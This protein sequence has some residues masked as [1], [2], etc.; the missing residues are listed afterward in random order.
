MAEA[1]AELA[2]AAEDLVECQP[3]GDVET[4]TRD[5]RTGFERPPLRPLRPA[6]RQLLACNTKIARSSLDQVAIRHGRRQSRPTLAHYP[7][8]INSIETFCGAVRNAIFTPG[9]ISF[10][11][12]VNATPFPFSSFTAPARS[13]TVIPK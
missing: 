2:A 8:W 13:S 6:Q 9:R 5:P 10:G 4:T 12:M 1:S 7:R 3:R 11:S